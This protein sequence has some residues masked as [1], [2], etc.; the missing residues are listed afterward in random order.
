MLGG[1]F[2]FICFV[3]RGPLF[4]LAYERVEV[5]ETE[6]EPHLWS[7]RQRVS[8][9]HL[10]QTLQQKKFKEKYPILHSF[11]Q[12]VNLQHRKQWVY[13]RFTILQCHLIFMG[14]KIYIALVNA[15]SRPKLENSK[16]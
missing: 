13:L 9:E 5:R 11:L 15:L 16:W 4:D 2:S 6:I 8:L 1:S 7:Y 10:S 12:V 3:E 14:K